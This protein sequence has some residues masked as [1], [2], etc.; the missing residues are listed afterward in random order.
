[1]PALVVGVTYYG[2]MV[3]QTYGLK[4]IDPGRSAFLTAAYCVLTPFVAWLVVKRRPY[5]INLL[6]GVICLLG[7]GFIALKPGSVSWPCR[8][9]TC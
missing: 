3:M 2:T 4:T 6:A 8:K 9:A 7:V 5:I 1:M